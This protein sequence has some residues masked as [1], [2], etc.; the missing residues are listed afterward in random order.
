MRTPTRSID[1][2]GDLRTPSNV[3]TT[4]LE[5]CER[6]APATVLDSATAPTHSRISPR[7]SYLITIPAPDKRIG[8]GGFCDLYLGLYA[9]PGRSSV[10][11]AMK[12]PRLL[13]PD[14][15]QAEEVIRKYERE[16]RIWS[17]LDHKN[18]LPFWGLLDIS[19]DV[20]LVSPWME[21]GDL[22]RFLAIRLSY[23]EDLNDMQSLASEEMQ[24]A[25]HMFDEANTI[26]GIASGLAYLHASGVIHGDLKAANILLGDYLTPMLCD[27][28]MSKDEEFNETSTGMKGC[29]TSRWMS[30]EL[31]DDSPKT[32]KTDIYAF[33]MTIVEIL[34]G[35]VPFPQHNRFRVITAVTSGER[36]SFEPSSRNGKDFVPLWDVA[37][38]CWKEQPAERLTADEAVSYAET[39]A[40]DGVALNQDSP[41]P[42][43]SA[44][45]DF[46]RSTSPLF[47][48]TELDLQES[49]EILA[50]D[51]EAINAMP[52]H[53]SE[54][55]FV[56]RDRDL[57][58]VV[59]Q[60]HSPS[61]PSDV[62]MRRQLLFQDPFDIKSHRLDWE[63]SIKEV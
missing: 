11:L 2:P 44:K 32:D 16:A 35:K 46:S 23:L 61:E 5:E 58:K 29:G 40:L 48:P 50:F 19:S 45:S 49:D 34:T 41:S 25:F 1:D 17:S 18:V 28:G 33:G 38:A 14:T 56:Y 59:V 57:A 31:M 39:L 30:P 47:I 9:P 8:G 24:V 37:A 10:K 55:R 54:E 3:R 7:I 21:H 22:S 13:G 20:Y 26:Y 42:P 27:F 53:A 4:L 51:S 43:A 63:W 6:N 15:S 52:Y 36:P 60:G 12:R 62:Q